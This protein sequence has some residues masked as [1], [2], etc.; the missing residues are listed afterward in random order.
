MAV[1][2][3]KYSANCGFSADFFYL[4]LL[5]QGW[6]QCCPNQSHLLHQEHEHPAADQG[7]EAPRPTPGIVFSTGEKLPCM[8]EQFRYSG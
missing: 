1:V 7:H 5:F 6:V 8:G 3:P 4:N 2:S